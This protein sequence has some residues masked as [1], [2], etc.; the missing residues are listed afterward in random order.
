MISQA[1]ICNQMKLYNLSG[2]KN[3]KPFDRS[4]LCPWRLRTHPKFSLPL[5][6][7]RSSG[8]VSAHTPV[9]TRSL[10][11]YRLSFSSS[12]ISSAVFS[13]RALNSVRS[14]SFY[15]PPWLFQT[16]IRSTS[17]IRKAANSWGVRTIAKDGGP[18][19][20][21]VRVPSHLIPKYI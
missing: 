20:T 7:P 19:I 15:E 21:A 9:H 12:R 14:S 17:F 11:I 3:C 18:P 4:F 10:S 6:R 2:L 5:S 16:G 8:V 1:I 13:L